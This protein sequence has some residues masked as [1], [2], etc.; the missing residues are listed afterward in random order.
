FPDYHRYDA[1]GLAELVRKGE[2]EAA[3]LLEEAIARTEA[4][5]PRL[6]AVVTRMYEEGRRVAAAGGEGPFAGVPFL[7]KD[8]LQHHAG[9]PMTCGSA[10]LTEYVPERD[11]EVV[12]RFKR[13]GLVIFG[14]TNVPEFGLVATTEPAVHGPTL[15]P[16]DVRRS[17][18]GSSGGSAA[19]VA[20]GLVPMAGANDGGGSIRIPAAWCGL[21]GLKPS[22]GR[23]P[24]GPYYAEIW[25][26]AVCDHVLTRTVR[27]SAA[28][29]DAIRGPAVGDPY[30]IEGPMRPYT[31]EA[32][33]PPGRLRIA[34]STRSPLGATVD[35][36]CRRAVE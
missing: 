17:P 35:P 12:S 32:T 5:N 2:V 11:I 34:F 9:V 15:N 16:W 27:D 6:N 1:T 36:E 10:A 25:G 7:L 23:V 28:M 18:G 21:F 19:A 14:K 26:G 24:V 4:V 30:R 8:L 13:A 3:E 22:R 33:L 31:E 20:A 29:L